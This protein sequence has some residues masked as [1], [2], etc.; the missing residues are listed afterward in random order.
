MG[1]RSWQFN[2]MPV[3]RNFM[4]IQLLVEGTVPR[5]VHVSLLVVEIYD[6]LKAIKNCKTAQSWPSSHIRS[7]TCMRAPS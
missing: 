3:S 6:N 4:V 7:H 1:W 2:H 5:I